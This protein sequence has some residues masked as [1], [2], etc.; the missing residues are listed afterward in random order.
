MGVVA[1]CVRALASR[2]CGPGVAPADAS[3]ADE[4]DDDDEDE[5]RAGDARPASA[6]AAW[7]CAP[8]RPRSV[9][10]AIAIGS[11]ARNTS[12]SI[13]SRQPLPRGK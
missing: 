6:S 2:A 10:D 1:K 4:D 13:G 12:P 8:D 9:I 5:A 7:N 3:T 11:S